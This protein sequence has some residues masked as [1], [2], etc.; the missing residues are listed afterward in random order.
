MPRYHVVVQILKASFERTMTS[1]NWGVTKALSSIIRLYVQ[2]H[3]NRLDLCLDDCLLRL[4]LVYFKL[5]FLGKWKTGLSQLPLPALTAFLFRSERCEK[6]SMQKTQATNLMWMCDMR[7]QQKKLYTLAIELCG[8]L[9]TQIA[10]VICK[11]NLEKN[12][13]KAT[14]WTQLLWRYNARGGKEVRG[15]GRAVI[16]RNDEILNWNVTFWA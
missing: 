9:V 16:M 14:K 6:P 8:I 5:S 3:K 15:P 10:Q 12:T 13:Q 4:L 1:Q 7:R 11:N 2:R